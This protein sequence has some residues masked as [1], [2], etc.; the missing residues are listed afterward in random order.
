[1]ALLRFL[2]LIVFDPNTVASY[3]NDTGSSFGIIFLSL[4]SSYSS[5]PE[6]TGVLYTANVTPIHTKVTKR[7]HL[8]NSRR[9]PLWDFVVPLSVLSADF[10]SHYN[11]PIDFHHDIDV[12]SETQFSSLCMCP[13]YFVC[14]RDSVP[15]SGSEAQRPPPCIDASGIPPYPRVRH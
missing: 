13:R 5:R 3:L 9:D 2:S 15:L 12:D 1:M 11:S 14:F 7:L 4:L 10:F 8:I 6:P